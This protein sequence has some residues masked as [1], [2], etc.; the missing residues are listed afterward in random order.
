M[1]TE[2]QQQA[3]PA[4]MIEIHG[5]LRPRNKFYLAVAE[6]LARN[7]ASGSPTPYEF[8]PVAIEGELISETIS[9]DRGPY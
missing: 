6:T 5:E 4:D 1:P 3:A 7:N 2:K 8:R 9:R